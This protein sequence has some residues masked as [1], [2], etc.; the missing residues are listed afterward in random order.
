MADTFKN[1][2]VSTLYACF[3][4]LVGRNIKIFVFALPEVREKKDYLHVKT[5]LRTDTD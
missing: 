3:D 1:S 4:L 2:K 5:P